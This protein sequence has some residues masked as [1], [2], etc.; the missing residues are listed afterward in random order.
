VLRVLGER[1]A[2]GA[3]EEEELLARVYDD[4]PARLHAMARRSLLAHLMKLGAEG[5]AVQRGPAWALVSNA[6]QSAA[7]QP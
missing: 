4:V 5:R 1:V 2:S 7:D 3:V 6:Q